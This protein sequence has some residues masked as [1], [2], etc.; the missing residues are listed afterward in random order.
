LNLSKCAVSLESKTNKQDFTS[1]WVVRAPG[2]FERMEA[3]FNGPAYAPH[4]HDTYAIGVTLEGK[5][6][7]NYRGS[8]R[9]N[10]VGRCLIIHPDE[11]HDGQ[12]GTDVGMHYRV[13][14]IDPAQIQS[15]LGGKSLPFIENGISSDPR[16]YQAVLGLLSE[17]DHDINGLEYQDALFDLANAMEVASDDR[18]KSRLTF[19]YHAAEMARQYIADNLHQSISL[20]I[21]EAISGRDRWN[22]SRDFRALFGTSPYRYLIMRRLQQARELMSNGMNLVEVAS[23]C[24]FADQ[25]HMNRHFKKTY[26]ITPK[27]WLSTIN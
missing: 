26:G 8:L 20:D 21:L 9:Y 4:R 24:D 12:A 22:L 19:N 3:F 23:H 6:G 2:E 1:D 11:L 7:F 27:K 13:G 18:Q 25:S 15:V 17:M 16:L 14:Y 10:E 5:Q